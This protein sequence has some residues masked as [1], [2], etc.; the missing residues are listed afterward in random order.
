[1]RPVEKAKP[2]DKILVQG[3]E[4]HVVRTY[5][6]KYSDA[7]VPLVE[8]IGQYC[9]YC[10]SN[11]SYGSLAIE[12]IEPKSLDDGLDDKFYECSWSN[13]LLTCGICN[14]IKNIKH[15]LPKDMHLPYKNNTFLSFVYYSNGIVLVNP[16]LSGLAKEHAQNLFD[17][18]G[19]G[20]MSSDASRSDRRYLKRSEA[21]TL[22]ERYKKELER[23][24]IKVQNIIDLAKGYGCWSIWFTVFE[25]YSDVR[26]SL[27]EQFPGTAKSCFDPNNAY[28]PIPRNPDKKED[29][30]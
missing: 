21:W 1:M 11:E 10:E 29:K 8:N 25:G 24:E 26:K 18:V 7:K 9:S 15:I 13:Y 17:L 14:S 19:L 12:Y 23:G 5:Y 2:N 28:Q 22:A 30:I 20:R 16:Q 6:N 4:E 27:I 3:E